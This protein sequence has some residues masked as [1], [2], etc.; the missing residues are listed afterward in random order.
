MSDDCIH[1]HRKK[2]HSLG[3]EVVNNKE[4]ADGLIN[5]FSRISTLHADGIQG[6]I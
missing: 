2:V 5:V 3:F 6:R 4:A 1:I